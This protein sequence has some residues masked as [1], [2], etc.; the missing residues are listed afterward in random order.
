LTTGPLTIIF[1]PTPKEPAMTIT[2]KSTKA[3][4]LAAYNALQAQSEARYVTLPLICNTLALVAR[5]ALA[6][7]RDVYSLGA[8]CRKG[9]DQVL[10][11]YAQPVLVRK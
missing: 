6:L 7:V 3:D 4:I 5:E 8:W 1:N 10:D 11:M 2:S 9:F